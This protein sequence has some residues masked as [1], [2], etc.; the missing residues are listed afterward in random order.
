METSIPRLYR[1]RPVLDLDQ[2][3]VEPESSIEVSGQNSTLGSSDG[4]NCRELKSPTV[5]KG[6][7]KLNVT[8]LNQ[9]LE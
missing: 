8:A 3:P 1:V 5:C 9:K 6:M 7:E 4:M 2:S